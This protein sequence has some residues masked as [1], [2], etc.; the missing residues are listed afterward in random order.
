MGQDKFIAEGGSVY[1]PICHQCRYW[2]Q[3]TVTC[4][5]YPHGIPLGILTGKLDH[6]EHLEGDGGVKFEPIQSG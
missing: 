3:H 5:A 6:H 1:Q 4:A 2:T